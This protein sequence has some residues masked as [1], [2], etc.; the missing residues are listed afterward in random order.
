MVKTKIGELSIDERISLIKAA[1]AAL[2]KAGTPCVVFSWRGKRFHY[3]PM[4]ETGWLSSWHLRHFGGPWV[5][6][7][8]RWATRHQAP[9]PS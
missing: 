6:Q 7:T 4:V 3:G 1:K 5:H 2:R 8:R 9:I